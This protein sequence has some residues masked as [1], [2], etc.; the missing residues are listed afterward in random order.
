[1]EK[2]RK[3]TAEE[4]G[5]VEVGSIVPESKA[6]AKEPTADVYSERPSHLSSAWRHTGSV[7]VIR[8]H[9]LADISFYRQSPCQLGDCEA[10]VREIELSSKLTIWAAVRVNVQVPQAR[11]HL[12]PL[13]KRQ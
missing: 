9:C 4:P 5:I 11:L 13:R 8:I 7:E 1:V 12:G 3:A 2:G 6:I 10:R